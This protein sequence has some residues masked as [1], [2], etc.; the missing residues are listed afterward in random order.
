MKKITSLLSVLGLIMMITCTASG[1]DLVVQD[2]GPVGT[3]ASIG[4][5]VTASVDGDR[6]IINNKV[7]ALPW[8]ED[9]TIN[10]SL[11]FLSAV[12]NQQFLVLGTYTVEHAPGREVNIIGMDNSGGTVNASGSGATSATIVNL[13]SCKFLAAN[14]SFN[15]YYFELNVASCNF[16]Y[17]TYIRLTDGSIIGN[18]LG[19]GD[20]EI[21]S[22][23]VSGTKTV[24]VIGNMS[25][26][27][28]TSYTQSHYVLIS[29]NYMRNTV[30]YLAYSIHI[31]GSKVGPK[32]NI[33]R[34]NS[35]TTNDYGIVLNTGSAGSFYIF[36]NVIADHGTADYGIQNLSTGTVTAAY[37]YI[38]YGFNMATIVGVSSLISNSTPFSFDINS[39]GSNTASNTIDGGA[40]GLDYYDLDLTRNDAGCLGGSYTINN[41][42]PITGTSS[43]VYFLEMPQEIIIGNSNA[44]KGYSF[45]R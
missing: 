24:K 4:A 45:D 13:M 1:T 28:I 17:G 16:G 37:N 32:E 27:Y 40:P 33:I 35:I 39:D 26:R 2:S 23:N 44:V 6:I 30:N 43:K 41:F 12:D 5:A 38:E 21:Y 10:K 8:I 31:R 18:D 34:N 25:I 9:I 7:S 36:N 3:Y 15:A 19:G 14:I 20:V 42:H 22:D 11:T 29:N